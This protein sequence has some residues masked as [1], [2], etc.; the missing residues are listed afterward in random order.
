METLSARTPF[1][2]LRPDEWLKLLLPPLLVLYVTYGAW[3]LAHRGL[4][5]YLGADYRALRASAEI[6]RSLGFDRVY[7]LSVQAEYQR[8]I[9]DAHT[10]IPGS[11]EYATVAV[12][13]APPF[14]AVMRALLL[15]EVV[16][17]YV[18]SRVGEVAIL[19]LY[20]WRLRR[21]AGATTGPLTLAGA[22]LALPVALELFFGQVNFWLLICLGEFM[23][24]RQ[25]GSHFV[26]G[27]WLGGL[28]L[29]PQTLIVLIPGLLISRETRL[30]LGAAASAFLLLVVS[31]LLAGQEGLTDLIGLVLRFRQDLPMVFPES[32][33]N[34]R[35]LGI[36]LAA[37]IAPHLA[38]GFVLA[39]M[40]LTFLLAVRMW[41]WRVPRQSERIAVLTLTSIAAANAVSWHSHVH[42]AL[43]ALAPLLYLHGRGVLPSSLL[44]V[45][46]MV[47]ALL[48]LP[49]AFLLGPGIAHNLAGLAM[50][51]ANLLLVIWAA[52]YVSP[53]MTEKL[54][55]LAGGSGMSGEPRL[56]NVSDSIRNSRARRPR[57]R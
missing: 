29:K 51:G 8:Q 27:L 24:S 21:A 37:I 14:I 6:S 55:A 38:L 42:Q 5:E 50:L 54:G 17:A 49:S 36:H 52:R 41:R 45:W 43:P 12:P 13:Y 30:L 53:R 46:L 9:L 1:R 23:L 15:M 40:G 22:F 3:S 39:G 35:A 10:R 25:R 47:P 26:G 48:F 20:F 32:M 44:N 16:P 18:L 19:A 28:L 11:M 34:W 57:A 33:M 31:L 56:G 2:D 4:F 7:D